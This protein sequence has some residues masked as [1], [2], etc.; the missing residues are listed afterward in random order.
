MGTP[1]IHL[2]PLPDPATAP[3]PDVDKAIKD[4]ETRRQQ[5]Q[6]EK[7]AADTERAQ[8]DKEVEFWHQAER[9]PSANDGA[10]RHAHEEEVKAYQRG[11]EA[12]EKRRQLSEED[13]RLAQ[14]LTEAK[15]QRATR[16]CEPPA[17]TAP[18]PKKAGLL[19]GAG[20]LAGAA[21]LLVGSLV[22][23]KLSNAST[24]DK[25]KPATQLVVAPKSTKP[26]IHTWHNFQV[27]AVDRDGNLVP[28]GTFGVTTG[29]VLLTSHSSPGVPNAPA[30]QDLG[31]GT[32]VLFADY[33]WE[34]TVT[35][36]PPPG[37]TVL[38]ESPTGGRV[39]IDLGVVTDGSGNPIDYHYGPSG[40]KYYEIVFQVRKPVVT[41][42]PSPVPPGQTDPG[43]TPKKGSTS[44]FPP[45]TTPLGQSSSSG[46]TGS[47]STSRTVVHTGDTGSSSN[48]SESVSSH[49]SDGASGSSQ[50]TST[51]SSSTD[52]GTSRDQTPTQTDTPPTT[53]QPSVPLG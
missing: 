10:V 37:W 47:S 51:G 35:Y 28:G 44:Q 5:I 32:A 17:K 7:T 29:P 11:N 36:S 12:L 41:T 40:K 1:Q 22:M 50:S 48:T 18:T 38:S 52:G 13:Y 25:P 24:P 27:K 15:Y 43:T 23:P 9:D 34:G 3:C 14:W 2:G 45:P 6:E 19:V 42:P 30:L 16:V 53:S 4:V 20:M 33:G 39:A 8:A 31:N 49:G 46:S 21:A 26:P